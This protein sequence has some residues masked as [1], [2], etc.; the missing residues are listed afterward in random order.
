M[1]IFILPIVALFIYSCSPKIIVNAEKKFEET[2]QHEGFVIFGMK[3]TFNINEG[4]Y[5]GYVKIKDSGL[6][7]DCS[8]ETVTKLAEAEARK[9]GGNTLKIVTHR[10]PDPFISQCHQITGNIYKLTNVSKYEKKIIWNENRKLKQIDFKGSIEN[11]PFEAA[12]SSGFGYEY[13]GR[14]FQG[15]VKFVV[16][17]VFDCERSYFKGTYQIDTVLAH[18]Q[19]HFD[20]TELYARK[21]F[22]KI[23]EEVKSIKDLQE[24]ANKIYD[25]FTKELQ[26]EQDR[27][28]SDIYPNRAKQAIWL[29]NLQEELKKYEKYANKQT[30]IKIL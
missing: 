3:D 2:K 26:I 8:Y 15:K 18:E 4:K 11:R 28:D 19:G 13:S 22:K 27:Y 5:I 24:N 25:D 12:T 20:M 1:K 17:T 16:T 14:V 29:K 21:F 9:V 23:T 7:I 6:T 30:F 10:L